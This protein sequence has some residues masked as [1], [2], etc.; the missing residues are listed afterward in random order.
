MDE[1]MGKQELYRKFQETGQE[2]RKLEIAL[3]GFFMEK[4][5]EARKEVYGTYL[6][7]R[8]RSAMEVLIRSEDVGKMEVL[9]QQGWFGAKE[10]EGFLRTAR[11]EKSLSALAWLL[12]LKDEKYGYEDRDFT[13]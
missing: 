6:K 11:A 2:K 3:E 13:L 12:R 10:L 4:G 9:E 8:I 1:S 5:E 7:R